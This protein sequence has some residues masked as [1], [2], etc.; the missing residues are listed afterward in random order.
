MLTGGPLY[1]QTGP[2]SSNAAP[3]EVL[4]MANSAPAAPRIAIQA[5]HWRAAEAPAELADLRSNGTNWQ[6]IHEW[7]VTLEIATRAANQLRELGYEVEVLPATVPPRYRADLFIAIH[8]DGFTDS[9]ANGFA[10]GAPRN[11]ATG[12][13]AQFAEE[14]ARAY[15]EATGLRM[16]EA[17]RRMRG[18]YAFNSRRYQHAIDPRTVGV[19]IETGFLTSPVDRQVILDAPDRSARGIVEAVTRFI[20]APSPNGMANAN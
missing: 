2:V 5:G 18:Y 14:L 20:P 19:I 10:V 13:A 11:D 8:A 12:R 6:G 9:S 7:Q 17:T 4:S 1:A 16:R 3:E 15:R